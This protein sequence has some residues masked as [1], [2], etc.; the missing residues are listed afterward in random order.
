MMMSNRSSESIPQIGLDHLRGHAGGAGRAVEAGADQALDAQ[1]R[2]VDR[3]R[4]LAQSER[5]AGPRELDAQIEAGA[6]GELVERPRHRP[7]RAAAERHVHQ[8]TGAEVAKRH[9]AADQARGLGGL[10][11][12][13]ARALQDAGEIVAPA[14][15]RAQVDDR[16]LGAFGERLDRVG[17]RH[18]PAGVAAISERRGNSQFV[19]IGADAIIDFHQGSAREHW[20]T[21]EGQCADGTTGSQRPTALHGNCSGNTARSAESAA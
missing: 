2:V 9:D 6:E 16:P 13:D 20:R 4:D 18:P 15:G 1:G 19:G 21:A 5:A 12:G 14:Q 17:R 10:G 11:G 3:D 7:V 8:R